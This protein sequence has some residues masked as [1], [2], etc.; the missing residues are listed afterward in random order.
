MEIWDISSNCKHPH[1]RYLL[2]PNY[3]RP[4]IVHG[5][6]CPI[7]AISFQVREITPSEC[8]FFPL[9]SKG[10]LAYKLTWGGLHYKYLNFV[11]S[12]LFLS[13]RS[14]RIEEN[15]PSERP[16]SVC[17]NCFFCACQA[18]TRA[19]SKLLSLKQNWKFLCSGKDS[20]SRVC[21]TRRNRARLEN[22]E[23]LA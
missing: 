7:L 17:I 11:N 3:A 8:L 1:C 14:V 9:S 4:F 20:H 10:C 23:D 12:V 19:E 2:W 18:W 13:V 22:L 16:H 15:A 21:S 6:N 5:K